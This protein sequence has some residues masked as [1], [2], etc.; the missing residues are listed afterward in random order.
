MVDSIVNPAFN[1]TQ[2]AR[3]SSFR[4]LTTDTN[5]RIATIKADLD[6]IP[7]LVARTQVAMAVCELAVSNTPPPNTNPGTPTQPTTGF[8]PKG[9]VFEGDSITSG[10]GNNPTPFPTQYGTLTGISVLNLAVSGSTLNQMNDNYGGNDHAGTKYSATTRDTMVV[11]SAGTNDLALDNRDVNSMKGYIQSLSGKGRATGYKVWVSTITLRALSPSWDQSRED[12]RVEYN[13]W[14]RANYQS[15]ADG[16]V[17][18]EA[19]ITLDDTYDG[20]HPKDSGALKMAAKLRDSFA[21]AGNAVVPGVVDSITTNGVIDAAKYRSIDLSST[22]GIA[23]RY[24]NPSAAINNLPTW[25]KPPDKR[26]PVGDVRNYQLGTYNEDSG[27]FASNVLHIAYAPDDPNAR[28]GVS[29]IQATSNGHYV[30]SLLPELSWV[31]YGSGL[32]G[33]EPQYWRARGKRVKNPVAMAHAFG[34]PGWAVETICVFDDGFICTVGANTMTNKT[35]TYLGAG[36]KPTGAAVTSS[37]EFLLVTV[38][39]TINL[40]GEVAV[41]SL[42]GLGEGATIAN[43]D[44]DR[45]RGK[46][47]EG[48]WGEWRTAHPGMHN[49]GNFAYMKVLGYIPL[50]GMMAPTEITA[51]TGHHRFRYLN[52]SGYNE[53]T[54]NTGNWTDYEDQRQRWASGDY[55]DRYARQGIAVVISKTESKAIF[56]DLKPL[57]SY[58]NGMYFGSRENYMKTTNI[59]DGAGQWPYTLDEAPSQKPTIIKT[60]TL[61]S[62]PTATLVYPYTL[63]NTPKR[64]WIATEDGKLRTFDLGGYPQGGSPDQIVEINAIDLGGTNPTSIAP[65]KEKAQPRFTSV[66]P[67]DVTSS[68]VVGVRSIK[69]AV[70]VDFTNNGTTGVIRRTFQDS[71]V[72]DL[73][74]VEDHDNHGTVQ[75]TC[76]IAD[77]V[78]RCVHNFR[79]GPIRMETYPGKPQ[80]G[81]GTS[82]NDQF[83]YSGSFPVPGYPWWVG[84]ANIS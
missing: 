8:V 41:V 67:D 50:P 69:A 78:G 49:L 70:F 84:T 11:G 29:D 36:K 72:K 39:D 81:M 38:W 32:D 46:D 4:Q 6:A 57:F 52:G 26:M 27:D 17:D 12:R 30:V 58:M 42:T 24:G 47:F 18:M 60:V 73:V 79:Y 31:R 9:V 3:A 2:V 33:T 13:T 53:T 74:R 77:G 64:A 71:R 23:Y 63:G 65:I 62:K 20:I 66:V 68:V 1:A 7:A 83:E 35:F 55:G 22:A 28:I 59:G 19:A 40:R 37:N 56:L 61:P 14:L 48:W 75:Y 82:G 10:T 45:A 15:F 43:Q 76:S 34:R 44:P 16:L 51:T 5:N 54:G 25:Y 21:A 80:F